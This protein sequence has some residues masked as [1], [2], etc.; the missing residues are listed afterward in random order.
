MRFLGQYAIFAKEARG[1]GKSSIFVRV[2]ELALN[3]RTL[4]LA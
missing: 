2:L 3:E 4:A 1:L